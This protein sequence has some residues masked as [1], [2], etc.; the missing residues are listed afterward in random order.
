MTKT[1][2][3]IKEQIEADKETS[4]TK[5]QI[6]TMPVIL[7]MIDWAIRNSN[8]TV[9][10]VAPTYR[11]AEQIVWQMIFEYLPKEAID[12][13]NSNKLSIILKNKTKIELKGADLEG[14]ELIGANL[15]GADFNT[16]FYV[17]DFFE[18]LGAI[19]ENN[20]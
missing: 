13:K 3:K 11:Q 17:D 2:L 8:K 7:K 4:K 20:K 6:K 12:K 1:I 15:R 16:K 19:V 5:I 14:D 18:A 9:W 10:Y